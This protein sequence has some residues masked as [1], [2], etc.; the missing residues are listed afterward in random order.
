VSTDRG[1]MQVAGKTV[2]QC[3]P[4]CAVAEH[5]HGASSSGGGGGGGG[6]GGSGGGSAVAGARGEL[7]QSADDQ[8]DGYN[9][10]G[11]FGDWIEKVQADLLRIMEDTSHPEL[12][13]IIALLGSASQLLTESQQQV[14]AAADVTERLAAKL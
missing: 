6:G 10:F 2:V 4:G 12:D 11:K 8:R 14:M 7:M 9:H 5:R 3:Q 1:Q 13:E